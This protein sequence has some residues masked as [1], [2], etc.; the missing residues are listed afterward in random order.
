[1]AAELEEIKDAE[2]GKEDSIYSDIS[3]EEREQLTFE[4]LRA[5]FF[6]EA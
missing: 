2:Q 4:I 1:M 3:P 6:E 5:N